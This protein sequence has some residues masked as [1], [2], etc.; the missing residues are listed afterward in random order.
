MEIEA[1]K[2]VKEREKPVE[3]VEQVVRGSTSEQEKRGEGREQP[4]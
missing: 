2:Y 1:E 3:A 4:V